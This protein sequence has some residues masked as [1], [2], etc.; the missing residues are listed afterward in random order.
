MTKISVAHFFTEFLKLIQCYGDI[1]IINSRNFNDGS[2]QF[3]C[4]IMSPAR[5]ADLNYI[6]FAVNSRSDVWSNHLSEAG[7]LPEDSFKKL[8][9]TFIFRASSDDM[10]LNGEIMPIT[11]FDFY[12]LVLRDIKKKKLINEQ[13]IIH[14]ED[15][16]E[17]VNLQ[18]EES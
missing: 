1:I 12:T 6:C 10:K 5:I 4:H 2:M 7:E 9:W 17:K 16:L 11:L 18:L 8:I 3:K 15:Y 13:E 14:F